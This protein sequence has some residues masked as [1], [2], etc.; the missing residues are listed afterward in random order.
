MVTEI[1]EQVVESDAIA[2]E[3]GILYEEHIERAQEIFE[4]VLGPNGVTLP[5]G[6]LYR[7]F[8]PKYGILWYGDLLPGDFETVKDLS[9]RGDEPIY[10]V[11]DSLFDKFRMNTKYGKHHELLLSDGIFQNGKSIKN[12]Y[13]E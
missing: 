1:N 9:S 10:V 6:T 13:G 2:N 4:D 12:R 3:D 11:K 5:G 8:S 7:L